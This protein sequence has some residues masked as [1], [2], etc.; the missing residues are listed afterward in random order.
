METAWAGGCACPAVG[1]ERSAMDV[2]LP[3]DWSPV[4]N[5]YVVGRPLTGASAPLYVGRDDVFAWLG[6]NLSGS[7]RPNAMLLYGRRRIGKTSTLYQLVEGERGRAIREGRSRSLFCAYVDLQRLAGRPTDEWL[8]RLARD[9]CQKVATSG[10]E[11]SVPDS[12]VLGETAFAAFDRCLDR[13]EQTLPGNSLILLAIDEFEQIRAEIASGTLGAEVLPFLRSQIQ[14]RERVVFVLSG[15]HGLLEPFW[16]NIVDLTARYELGPLT[17]E[18]T[19]TLVC[20][21]LAGRLIVSDDAVE[22]IWQATQGHPFLI[23]TICHSLV[24]D[25]NRHHT[26]DS[27]GPA[28]VR[29]AIRHIESERAYDDPALAP[30]NASHDLAPLGEAGAQ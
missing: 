26:R 2:G 14:H 19:V 1:E 22:M 12:S 29:R 28:N 20:A 8:R 21:P 5:P 30:A 9:V 13:L 24:S 4:A 27:I 17:F 15:G 25:A 6:E 11:R 3:N 18:Q 7:P 23:Q 10:L 16:N